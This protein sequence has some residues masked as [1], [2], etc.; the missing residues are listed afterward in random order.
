MTKRTGRAR[1]RQWGPGDRVVVT[2]GAGFVGS[3]VCERLLAQGAEVIAV[4]SL[5]TG[6]RRNVEHLVEDPRFTLLV[7][8]VS[9]GVDVDGPVDLVLHLA[10]PASPVHYLQLPIETL[11]VGSV[12]TMNALDLAARTRARFLLASTS[13][14]YGDPL[15]H[16]QRESYWGNVNPIGPRSVYDEAKRFAEAVTAAYGR[17]RGVDTTIARI[18]NTYG[19]RMAVNDGRVVPTFAEQALTSAPMT[20]AG[21]GS[22]TRSLCYVEDTVEGLLRLAGSGCPGPVNIG[23]DH[24]VTVLDLASEIRELTGSSSS[25]HFVDLPEDDPRQR[26]PD[27]TIAREELGWEP[28]VH[29]REGLR[30]TLAWIAQEL[31]PRVGLRA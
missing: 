2:G 23:N 7:C 24:E 3:W 6:D 22:Q 15:E 30:T 25:V 12:G 1:R 13:E 11:Q 21:D 20:V 8:D 18:F 17:H 31:E 19:P 4:D 16:P 29:M 26:R 10:S 27:L 5:V 9:S 14:V 28:R